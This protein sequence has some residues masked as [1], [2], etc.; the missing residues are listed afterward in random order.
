[1]KVYL[2]DSVFPFFSNNDIHDTD[3]RSGNNNH[4]VWKCVSFVDCNNNQISSERE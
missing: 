2:V 3:L 1:M 4:S